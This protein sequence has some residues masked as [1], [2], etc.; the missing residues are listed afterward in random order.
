MASNESKSTSSSSITLSA[1][2]Q[3]I[4]KRKIETYDIKQLGNQLQDVNNVQPNWMPELLD[5][6]RFDESGHRIILR[7]LILACILYTRMLA[8]NKNT[9]SELKS[10]THVP[11]FDVAAM[12]LYYEAHRDQLDQSVNGVLT[13]WKKN[14]ACAVSD[15]HLQR[16]TCASR[17][18][19][20]DLAAPVKKINAI[21]KQGIIEFVQHDYKDSL[22]QPAIGWFNLKVWQPWESANTSSLTCNCIQTIDTAIA[23]SSSNSSNSRKRTSRDHVERGN[24]NYNQSKRN[25]LPRSS[26]HH[27]QVSTSTNT[28]QCFW[29]DAVFPNVPF[30]SLTADQLSSINAHLCKTV[31]DYYFQKHIHSNS[32]V[33]TTKQQQIRSDTQSNNSDHDS[34][35][36]DY[37]SNADAH[38]G[39]QFLCHS[40]YSHKDALG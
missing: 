29:W 24:H 18:P 36:S 40:A 39:N 20:F 21:C 8:M 23:S 13:R 7:D 1:R 28:H 5:L 11:V 16:V 12:L 30:P 17:H 3:A 4:I 37:D 25:C 6:V 2:R 9:S 27:D 19:L 26:G 33:S 38:I 10:H 32:A 22:I 14:K 15:T 34:S 31:I 35:D